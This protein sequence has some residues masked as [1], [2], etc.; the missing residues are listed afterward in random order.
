MY[1]TDSYS[2]YMKREEKARYENMIPQGKYNWQIEKAEVGQVDTA[3]RLMI[4]HRIIASDKGHV[5]RTHFEFVNW[6]ANEA[7]PSPKPH[8]ERERNLRGLSGRKLDSYLGA[9]ATS[10]SSTQVQGD[11]LNAYI[12]ELRAA[13]DT[14]EVSELMGNIGL[15]LEGQQITGRVKHKDEWTNLIPLEFDTAIGSAQEVAV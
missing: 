10:P 1:N 7:S 9:L 6:Y 12:T 2:E 5:G 11:D 3:P 14:E 8:A 13:D 15:L 4:Q